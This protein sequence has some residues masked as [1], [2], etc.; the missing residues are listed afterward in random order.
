MGQHTLISFSLIFPLRVISRPE[1]IG[2]VLFYF[3]YFFFH[4]WRPMKEFRVPYVPA[5][6]QCSSTCCHHVFLF[7]STGRTLLPDRVSFHSLRLEEFSLFSS[8]S[9]KNIILWNDQMR[10]IAS[11]WL[12]LFCF[13]CFICRGPSPWCW[14]RSTTEILHDNQVK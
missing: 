2:G 9:S 10:A 14:K 8:I 11:Q 3:I 7:F 5:L 1:K 13:S 4:C 6:L 12:N